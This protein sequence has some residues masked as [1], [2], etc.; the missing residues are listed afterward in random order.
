MIGSNEVV[1]I[2]VVSLILFGPERLV[3][4]AR[5]LGEINREVKKLFDYAS[6]EEKAG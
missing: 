3:H 4:V 1:V 2:L 6:D 5:F